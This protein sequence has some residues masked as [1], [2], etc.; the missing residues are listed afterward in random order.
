MDI[1][2]PHRALR[3]ISNARPTPLCPQ[4]STDIEVLTA[5]QGINQRLNSNTQSMPTCRMHCVAQTN[6]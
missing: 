4:R 3:G 2:C 6:T 1:G 5:L